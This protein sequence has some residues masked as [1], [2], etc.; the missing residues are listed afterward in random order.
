L[1]DVVCD[2]T[3]TGLPVIP[4]L[5]GGLAFGV[6]ETIAGGVLGDALTDPIAAFFAGSFR[7]AT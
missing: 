3:D 7:V 2:A 6:A 5:W 4:A 1:P